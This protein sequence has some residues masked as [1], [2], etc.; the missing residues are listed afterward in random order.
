MVKLKIDGESKEHKFKRIAENRTKRVL[1]YL[2][3]LGNCSNKSVYSYSEKDLDKIFK[4]I[5]KEL[6]RV[7]ALFYR[8]EGE[9]FS[10]K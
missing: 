3:R 2:R 5:Q 6:T 1:Q 10:L 8:G 7:K 9:K 4:A